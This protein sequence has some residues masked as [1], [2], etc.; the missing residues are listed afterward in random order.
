MTCDGRQRVQLGKHPKD[1]IQLQ[2]SR[3]LQRASAL[4]PRPCGSGR[5]R[6]GK[7]SKEAWWYH[8]TGQCRGT[9]GAQARRGWCAP[10]RTMY[11]AAAAEAAP[12][13]LSAA[14]RN[15]RRLMVGPSGGACRSGHP[16]RSRWQGGGSPQARWAWIVQPRRTWSPSPANPPPSP[17]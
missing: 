4:K 3:R 6:T 2:P 5:R 15:G 7:P 12:R 9:A 11:S 10:S 17:W 13:P 14:S 16:G 1:L 8:H